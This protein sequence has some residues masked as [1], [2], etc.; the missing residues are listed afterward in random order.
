[1]PPDLLFPSLSNHSVMKSDLRSKKRTQPGP[2]SHLRAFTMLLPLPLTAHL[3]PVATCL[4]LSLV[5]KFSNQTSI[6]KSSGKPSSSVKSA[7]EVPTQAPI[8]PGTSLTQVFIEIPQCSFFVGGCGGAQ[9]TQVPRLGIK[10]MPQQP[11]KQ[12]Q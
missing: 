4:Q 11:P 6:Q 1:M 7:L 12:M 9:H 2:H 5:L 3:T 10:P 8:P